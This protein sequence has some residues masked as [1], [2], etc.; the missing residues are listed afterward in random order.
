MVS[1]YT[2]SFYYFI[3]TTNYF[4]FGPIYNIIIQ[5]ILNFSSPKKFINLFSQEDDFKNKAIKP[6]FDVRNEADIEQITEYYKIINLK[7]IKDSLIPLFVNYKDM[8][9]KEQLKIPN[10]KKQEYKKA[11]YAFCAY[12]ALLILSIVKYIT[13]GDTSNLGEE[14]IPDFEPLQIMQ[15]WLH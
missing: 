11:G 2:F 4:N 7:T 14:D 15:I 8:L 1:F 12:I 3:R 5:I 9:D 13:G 10:K 6:G